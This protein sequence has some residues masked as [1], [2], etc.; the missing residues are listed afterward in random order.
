MGKQMSSAISFLNNKAKP[1]LRRSVTNAS[2]KGK[3]SLVGS[4]GVPIL[5]SRGEIVTLKHIRKLIEQEKI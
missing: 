1:P 2:M 4:N 3:K 5:I